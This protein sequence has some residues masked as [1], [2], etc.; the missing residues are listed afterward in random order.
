MMT[1]I[2]VTLDYGSIMPILIGNVI[3]P[4][5]D[6]Y[7]G[8]PSDTQLGHKKDRAIGARSFTTIRF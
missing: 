3:G 8:T 6:F 4:K 7:L 1:S 2:S 5:V